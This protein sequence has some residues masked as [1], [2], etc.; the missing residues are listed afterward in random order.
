MPC[1]ASSLCSAVDLPVKG[2]PT[3]LAL[4]RDL[5]NFGGVGGG[6]GG[7]TMSKSW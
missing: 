7:S 5:G 3:K 1:S 6:F 2:L 4:R